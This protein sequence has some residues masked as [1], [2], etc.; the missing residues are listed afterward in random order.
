MLVA[1]AFVGLSLVVCSPDKMATAA[2]VRTVV[3][4]MQAAATAT[5]GNLYLDAIGL[6]AYLKDNGIQLKRVHDREPRI[7]DALDDIGRLT[8]L[9][10]SRHEPGDLVIFSHGSSWELWFFDENNQL[11]PVNQPG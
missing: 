9:D 11:S 7:L 2:N 6:Q 1:I 8:A 4:Q 3:H 5:P 10:I